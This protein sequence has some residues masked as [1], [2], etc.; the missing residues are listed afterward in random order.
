MKKIPTLFERDWEGDRSRVLSAVRPGCEWVLAGEG[1]AMRKLDG[2]CCMVRDNMLYK[3]RVLCKGERA[4]SDF[5]IV[6][7][8][9]E[10]GKIAGWMPV[11]DGPEDKY[12][13][14]A[15]KRDAG[16]DGVFELVGPKVQGNPEWYD[17]HSLV[18]HEDAVLIMDGVPRTFEGLRAWLADRDIEGIVFHHPDGRMAKI[19]KRDFG[20][21]R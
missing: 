4:P 2:A 6:D 7:A 9:E 19:K 14:E 3:R 13:R 18:W 8:D 11:G 10:T 1:T 17:R 16:F 12:Y 21:R 5:E 20:F 15:L